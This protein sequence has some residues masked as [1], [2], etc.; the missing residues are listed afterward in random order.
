ML[1]YEH[2]D[3]TLEFHTYLNESQ[4]RVVEFS[5]MT[6]NSETNFAS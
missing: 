6:I 2:M 4:P 3:R 5:L 1:M